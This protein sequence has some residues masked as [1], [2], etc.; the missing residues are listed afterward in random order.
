MTFSR[1]PYPKPERQPMQPVP[2]SMRTGSRMAS[3]AD[4][5]RAPAQPVSLLAKPMELDPG[6]SSAAGRRY[7]GRVAALGCRLCIRLGFGPGV[8]EVHHVRTGQGAAQRA[9]DWLTFGACPTCHRGPRGLH[10]DRSLLRQANVTEMDLLADVI[11]ELMG[12]TSVK[13][14]EG[15][16]A[17]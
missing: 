11:A 2:P 12:Q 4:L 10:G 9:S 17:G 16:C 15:E 13:I 14:N 5:V 3:A 7:M 1:K 6:P 8:C